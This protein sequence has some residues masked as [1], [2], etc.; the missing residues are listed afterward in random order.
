MWLLH[1]E[2]LGLEEF[3]ESNTPPYAIL[4]HTWINEEISF[5]EMQDA[6]EIIRNKSGFKKI[7]KFCSPAKAR[8]FTYGW[9]DTCCIDKRSSAELS[10]AINS[11]YRY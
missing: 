1:T 6:D 10:E 11:M 4:S 2:T 7:L 8:G 5:V 9:V 3:V